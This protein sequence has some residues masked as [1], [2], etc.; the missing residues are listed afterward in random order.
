M[1]LIDLYRHSVQSFADRVAEVRP[2]Q[3][4]GA[5]PCVGWDV[6]ALVN[7]VVSEELWS[8]P[9]FAGATIAE[10][11]DRFEGDLLGEDPVTAAAEAAEDAQAAVSEVGALERTVH[12]S[13]GDTPAEE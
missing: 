7:H 6:R 12:L 1:A 10:V 4:G 13:F 9:L 3:W 8:V 5:T 11:G 2:E